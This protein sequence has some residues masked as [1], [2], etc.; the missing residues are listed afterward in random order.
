[1]SV[2]TLDSNGDTLIVHRYTVNTVHV[3]GILFLYFWKRS[4]F[5]MN[6]LGFHIIVCFA[7]SVL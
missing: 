7:L 2:K 4:A 6:R 1:M 3:L 5:T